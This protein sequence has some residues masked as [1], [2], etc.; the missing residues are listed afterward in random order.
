VGFV[1]ALLVVAAAV[2]LGVALTPS[3]PAS[4]KTAYVIGQFN[5]AGGNEA[6]GNKIAEPPEALIGEVLTRRPLFI[7][8][9]EACQDWMS[10]LDARLGQYSIAFDTVRVS[11]FGRVARCQHPSDFG[12]A[13]LYRDDL[14]IDQPLEAYDLGTGDEPTAAP[15]L[16]QREMVC[17]RSNRRKLA[18]CSAHLTNRREEVRRDEARVA[19]EIIRGRYAGYTVFF[20]GDLNDIP[21][22]AV[23]NTFA[24][25]KEVDGASRITMGRRKLDYLFVPKDVQVDFAE[26]TNNGRSD[27]AMLWAGIRY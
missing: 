15:E 10:S 16:E 7:T 17:V 8:I 9:Q 26:V 24:D 6:F 27:H 11:K 25:F 1:V 14:G 5:M 3:P 12:N 23:A 19:R 21:N 22:S 4:A 18:V 2:T 13:I 20:G